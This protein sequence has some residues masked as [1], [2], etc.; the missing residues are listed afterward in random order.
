MFESSPGTLRVLAGLREAAARAVDVFFRA[1]SW[2]IRDGVTRAA[3][4][5][6][7]SAR[8]AATAEIITSLLYLI[9]LTDK[10][11]RITLKYWI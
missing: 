10:R 9:S 11:S 5:A 8:A 7:T 1:G 4:D 2:R 3:G 6:G